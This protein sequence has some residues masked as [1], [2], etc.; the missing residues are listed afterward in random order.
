MKLRVSYLRCA[1]MVA[2]LAICGGVAYSEETAPSSAT[3][4]LSI[5]RSELRSVI[6]DAR[7][8]V[9]PALVNIQLVTT[10]YAGGKEIRSRSVG[11]G[12]IVDSAG[13]VLTNQHVTNRGRR[14]RCTL[15]D[16]REVPA[17][18]V[19][20]DPLTDLAVLKLDLEALGTDASKL[21]VATIGDSSQIE[22]G[23]FVMAMGSPL[24]L[25][26]SV[27]LGIVSNTERVFAGGLIDDNSDAMELSP[28]QR[29]GLFTRWIQHDALIQPGNSGGPLVNLRGEIIGVNELGGNQ[30]GF[31]IPSNLAKQVLEA[32][33]SHGEV[34]R[35]WLGVALRPIDKTGYERGVLV[36]SIVTGSPAARGGLKPGDVLVELDGLAVTVRFAE[37]I[38]LLMQKIADR[39]VG[40]ELAA[41][42]LR[43]GSEHETRIVTAKLE[44]D[45]GQEEELR[46]WG[47]TAIEITALAALQ[48][49]LTTTDGVLITG[50]RGGGSAAS[51]RPPLGTADVLRAIDGKP[52]KNM[53]DLLAIYEELSKREPAPEKILIEF[54]RRGDNY[55]TVLEPAEDKEQPEPPRSLPK[56]WLGVAVQPLLADLATLMNLKEP[57]FRVTQVYPGTT[58]ATAGLQVG[59][60]ITQLN[61]R[62]VAPRRPEDAGLFQRELRA[63]D[64]GEKAALTLLRQGEPLEIE[65][66]LEASRTLPDETRRE[67]N[68][69]FDL[70]VREI[71]FFD[72]VE[73]RWDDDVRGVIVLSAE[74]AGW[75]GLAGVSAGD[76][77][78]KIGESPVTDV[79]TFRQALDKTADQKPPRVV[80]EILRGVQTRFQFAEP[81]WDPLG[82]EETTSDK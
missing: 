44:K 77:I 81:E 51:A 7:S 40:T 82:K 12:T 74:P 55:V 53:S 47:M 59:D 10:M 58:A 79:A 16:R 11:S 17:T 35:S 19:G 1:W 45:L 3:D 62:K 34:T 18:L 30:I 2:A 15:Y 25:S 33:V 31:A 26:R 14:F 67:H 41:K 46:G 66:A 72:R 71:T 64:I 56:A 54:E 28:G 6:Q 43:D 65:V 63:L 36:N 70:L 9:F 23:D 61:G 27:T 68:G 73:H 24:A 4:E 75:A 76:L 69:D 49:R 37:E 78:Q 42:Y 13:H 20:E 8:K 50:V 38:P 22:I 39:P 5:V 21:T 80:F 52:V 48:R 29:T 32:I 60:V 57:G